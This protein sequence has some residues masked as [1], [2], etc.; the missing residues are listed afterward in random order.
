MAH[1]EGND[2]DREAAGLSRLGGR[3]VKGVELFREEG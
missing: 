3:T 1:K 2:T